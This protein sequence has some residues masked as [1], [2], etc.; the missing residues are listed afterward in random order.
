MS[1]VWPGIT[2][3]GLSWG[4]QLEC[5]SRLGFL[6]AQGIVGLLTN[7]YTSAFITRELSTMKVEDVSYL[8]HSRHLA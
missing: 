6:I 2:Q 8:F 5:S 1:D 4:Q 7:L 3:T